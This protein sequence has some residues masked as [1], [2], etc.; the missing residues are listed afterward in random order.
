MIYL[1][2]KPLQLLKSLQQHKKSDP[3]NVIGRSQ[4]IKSHTNIFKSVSQPVTITKTPKR[5]PQN[6]IIFP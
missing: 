4:K 1:S 6:V 2:R 3:Q 5:D